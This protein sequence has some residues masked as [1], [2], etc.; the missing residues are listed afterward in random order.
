MPPLIKIKLVLNNNL[1]IYGVYDSGSN[2]S[3]INSRLLKI[4]DKRDNILNKTNLKTINGVKK[5]TGKIILNVKIFDLERKMSVFVIDGENFDY[6][7]LIGLDCIKNFYLTQ[8]ENLEI[9]QKC[10]T[11][12]SFISG[13]LITKNQ[14]NKNTKVNNEEND[15]LQETLPIKL[16]KQ[17]TA[18]EDFK[19]LE[20]ENVTISKSLQDRN[21]I[22]FNEQVE[23]RNFGIQ[24][25]H[26]NYDQ[27]SEIDKLIMENKSVFAKDKYDVGTVKG[28]EAHIEL[29]MDK[30]C[31]KRPYRCTAEDKK[32]IEDQV[33][34]L[35]DRHLVEESH[36]PFAAPV[37]LAFKRD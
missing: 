12:A 21:E 34:K 14:E 25:N 3:L 16:K 6:D 24:I 2:V 32:E 37:M 36:S 7:F 1:E 33:A 11:K 35:L 31:S 10:P 29:I 28:Y 5:A 13:E 18:S 17:N 8:N 9:K 26:L 27:Q 15:W 30:Y 4:G 20:P 19:K 23:T 22:N